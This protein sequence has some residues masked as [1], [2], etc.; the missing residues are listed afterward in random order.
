[1]FLQ[2]SLEDT[3]LFDLTNAINYWLKYGIFIKNKKSTSKY[4]K[5]EYKEGEKSERIEIASDGCA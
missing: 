4:R 5:K 3:L 1:M 2:C